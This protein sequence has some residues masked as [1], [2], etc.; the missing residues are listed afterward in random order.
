MGAYTF[1]VLVEA[2]VEGPDAG[3]A[4]DLLGSALQEQAGRL[5]DRGKVVGYLHDDREPYPRWWPATLVER[6]ALEREQAG[7]AGEKKA[8]KR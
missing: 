3:E 8:K 6:V 5:L 7:A 1:L 4:S 2:T